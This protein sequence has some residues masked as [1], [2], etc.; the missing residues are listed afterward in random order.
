VGVLHLKDKRKLRQMVVAVVVGIIIH[1]RVSSNISSN[2]P[3]RLLA[4]SIRRMGLVWL[5]RVSARCIRVLKHHHH[6]ILV[7]E[8]WV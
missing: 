3:L 8:A 4:G 7:Q 5:A 2:L 1:R 6:H